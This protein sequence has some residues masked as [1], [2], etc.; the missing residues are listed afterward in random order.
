MKQDQAPDSIAV[1][2][3]AGGKTVHDFCFREAAYHL[4]E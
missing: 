1:R 4:R 2:G 3:L